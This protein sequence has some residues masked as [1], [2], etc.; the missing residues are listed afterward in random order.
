MF[1][2]ANCDKL[3]EDTFLVPQNVDFLRF[4][5]INHVYRHQTWLAGKST[6]SFDFLSYKY[7]G[8]FPA[9]DAEGKTHQSQ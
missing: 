1:N 8:D 3:P 9:I 2:L 4:A 6:I 5:K 7:P